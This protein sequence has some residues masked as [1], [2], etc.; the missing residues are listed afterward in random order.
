MFLKAFQG[1]NQQFSNRNLVYSLD[2]LFGETHL[3]QSKIIDSGRSLSQSN[4]T[5]CDKIGNK[6]SVVDA[7]APQSEEITCF[8][9]F[10][11]RL[12]AKQREVYYD[13]P[14]KCIKVSA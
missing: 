6:T 7:T 3:S 2:S 10:V 1:T 8:L 5:L 9:T 11:R 13:I 12:P 14:S 4:D